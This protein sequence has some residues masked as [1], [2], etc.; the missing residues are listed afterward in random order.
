MLAIESRIMRAFFSDVGY[1]ARTFTKKPAFALTAILTLALGIGASA[2]IFS[3]VNAVLLRPL[4]YE[5][6]GRLVHIANDLRARNVSDFP[7]PPADFHDLR[8]QAQSFDGIAALIT[9]RQVFVTPGQSEAE[10]VRTGAATPN[11]FRVLGAR[12]ALGTDWTDADGV[13]LPQPPPAAPGQPP[14]APAT[15]PPPPRTILSYEF[16]QRR[17]GGNPAMVGTV[18]RLG[19]QPFEIIGVLQPGFELLYPPTST[20]KRRPTTGRRCASTSRPD[21]GSTFSFG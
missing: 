5:Q 15:P 9:G 2:A 20:S 21:R 10:Q 7:W 12:M 8:M 3:V 18:I 19:D 17:F 1:A 6:P 4:P 14:A 16:W 11:L 13:P